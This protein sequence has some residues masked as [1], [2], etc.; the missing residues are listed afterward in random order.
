MMSETRSRPSGRPLWRLVW[1][2]AAGAAATVATASIA[3]AQG[4]A[5][6]PRVEWAP[7]P[8]EYRGCYYYR[9]REHCGRYCYLEVNGKRYCQRRYREARPQAGP[10]HYYAPEPRPYAYDGGAWF[11]MK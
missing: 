3:G 4:R 8:L 7:A 1:T 10:E 11:T 5:P 9:G 2:V 6:P